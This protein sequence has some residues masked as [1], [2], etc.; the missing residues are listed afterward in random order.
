M[1][2]RSCISILLD[3][4]YY[5]GDIRRSYPTLNINCTSTCITNIFWP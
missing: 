1:A 2:G 3:F 5:R 4:L